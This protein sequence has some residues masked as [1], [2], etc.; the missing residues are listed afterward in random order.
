MLVGGA[1]AGLLIIS[2]IAVEWTF[3]LSQQLFG[4]VRYRVTTS[5]TLGD[6]GRVRQSAVS[7][8]CWALATSRGVRQGVRKSRIGEDNHYTLGDGSVLI[9]SDLDPCR[10]VAHAPP[11]GTTLVLAPD[12]GGRGTLRPEGEAWRFDNAREPTM[13]TIYDLTALFTQP[14]D[15][16]LI[17]AASLT[18][19]AASKDVTF[20]LEQRLPWLR[21]V[22]HGQAAQDLQDYWELHHHGNF[23]GFRAAVTQLPDDAR[24]PVRDPA[25][26]GPVVIAMQAPCTS[27]RLC[28]QRAA[29]EG[30]SCGTPRG[31]LAGSVDADFGTLSYSID[32]RS[33]GRIAVLYRELM[34][35]RSRAPGDR[36][37]PSMHWTPRVCMDGLCVAAD[38]AATGM[39]PWTQFYYPVRNELVTVWPL[40]FYAPDAFRRS[41]ASY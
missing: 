4:S 20:T 22:P 24:C 7:S 41:G 17:N 27:V 35:A 9:L 39:S 10:W 19:E 6:H 28:M 30:R 13:V 31:W 34:L 12:G 2:A 33:P 3:G 11:V 37:N 16:L 29:Q 8:D 15:G 26:D 1:F 23:L 21:A 36:T 5:V 38:T 25:A 18:V 14:S 40:F 32:E